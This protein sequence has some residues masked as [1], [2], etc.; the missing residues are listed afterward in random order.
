MIERERRAIKVHCR[1]LASLLLAGSL[2]AC[3][4]SVCLPAKPALRACR[5]CRA[6]TGAHRIQSQH[7]VRGSRNA[8]RLS[9]VRLR[10]IRRRGPRS[11]REH[12][13]RHRIAGLRHR[14]NRVSQR[15]AARVPE[16]GSRSRGLR[17]D[18]HRHSYREPVAE[19]AREWGPV[20]P[21][22]RRRLPLLPLLHGRG[23]ERSQSAPSGRPGRWQLHGCR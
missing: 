13:A 10:P 17:C 5:E 16:R 6:S 8:C 4:F 18:D 1:I 21:E 12:R 3:E 15:L 14:R 20:R 19:M 22:L 23:V 11:R 2:S 9:R 7:G